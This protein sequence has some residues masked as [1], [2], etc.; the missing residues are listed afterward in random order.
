MKY[1]Y[2]ATE[3]IG[4]IKQMSDAFKKGLQ[5]SCAHSFCKAATTFSDWFHNSKLNKRRSSCCKN[6]RSIWILLFFAETK[7]PAS[8]TVASDAHHQ[9]NNKKRDLGLPADAFEVTTD[10]C[11]VHCEQL[12]GRPHTVPAYATRG[13]VMR[14]RSRVALEDEILDLESLTPQPMAVPAMSASMSSMTG[15]SISTITNRG[16]RILEVVE[17]ERTPVQTPSPSTYLPDI[18]HNQ[19]VL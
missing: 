5:Q 8:T 10:N 12:K 4:N 18:H 3:N 13:G 9:C 6:S 11:C 1:A 14:P 16:H 17:E 2:I 7:I 15:S 19:K